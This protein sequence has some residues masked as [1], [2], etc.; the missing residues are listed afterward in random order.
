M[1]QRKNLTGLPAFDVLEADRR[2]DRVW[3]EGPEGFW[4]RLAPGL[5]DDEGLTH[6]H[7]DSLDELLRRLDQ[8]DDAEGTTV[9]P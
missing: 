7:E 3:D 1:S 6:L 5:S 9:G 2:V 4:L 8:V